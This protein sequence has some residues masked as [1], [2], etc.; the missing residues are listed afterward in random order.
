MVRH[1]IQARFLQMNPL[2]FFRQGVNHQFCFVKNHSIS[3]PLF[4]SFQRKLDRPKVPKVLY[5][6]AASLH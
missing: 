6:I 4:S 1:D 3:T 5:T 2:E